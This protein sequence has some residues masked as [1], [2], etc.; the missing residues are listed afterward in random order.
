MITHLIEDRSSVISN[1]GQGNSKLGPTIFTYSKLPG[2]QGG[3][4]PGSSGECELICFA[5]RVIRNKPVWDLWERN[6][7]LGPE[8]PDPPEY[9]RIIRLHVSG[10]FDTIGY[11]NAWY[12]IV[13]HRPT[14]KFFVYTRSWRK[15]D[16]LESLEALRSL[17]N[18]QMFASMDYSIQELPPKGWRRA[19]IDGDRRVWTRPKLMREIF[20]GKDAIVCPQE[21]G[22]VPDCETCKFCFKSSDRDLVFLEH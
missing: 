3:T 1:Y 11:I 9:A 18:I 19:W 13:A 2:R 5:K 12:H 15:S 7:L 22:I 16:L 14:V 21:A 4:C 8:I 6:T 10:D 17:P 20:D